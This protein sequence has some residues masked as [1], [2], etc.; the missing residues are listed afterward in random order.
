M[1]SWWSRWAARWRSSRV[2][3]RRRRSM[4]RLRAVVVIQPPG[5]GGTPVT[6]QRSAAMANASATASSARSM[7]PRMRISVAVHRPAS[8]RNTVTR[9]SLTLHRTHL[10]RSCAG[11]GGL[12][13]PF[14]G[15]V[16]VGSLDDPEAAHLLLGLGVGAVGHR[17]LTVLGPDDG[18]GRCRM[19]PGAEHPRAGALE[20]LVVG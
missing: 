14:E 7:S 11:G 1:V 18:G 15:G 4:A 5:F 2:A 13:G 8:R 20:L 6:G 19:E 16:Q 9:S 10:D 17:H 3:S 12:R